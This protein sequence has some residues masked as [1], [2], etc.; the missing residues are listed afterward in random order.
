MMSVSIGIELTNLCVAAWVSASSKWFGCNKKC[1]KPLPGAYP[2]ICERG[3][4]PFLSLSSLPFRSPSS[5][6]P[7]RIWAP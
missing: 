5:P 7:L 2:G 1:W 4:N 3:D 6:R